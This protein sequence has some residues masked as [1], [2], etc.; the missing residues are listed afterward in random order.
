MRIVWDSL[1]RSPAKAIREKDAQNPCA[2]TWGFP[3]VVC[4]SWGVPIIRSILYR[5]L[6]WDPKI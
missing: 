6:Y 5:D 1:G 2:I 3:T 4:T